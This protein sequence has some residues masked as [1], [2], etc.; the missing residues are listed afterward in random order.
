M[1]N[2]KELIEYIEDNLKCEDK[3]LKNAIEKL[4]K[5]YNKKSTRLDKIVKQSDRQQSSLKTAYEE[6]SDY[7]ENL[8]IKVQD[9]IKKRQDNE[10]MLMQQSKMA[11]MGEM[12]DAVA[13]QWKQPLNII[14][15]R[16]MMLGMDFEDGEVNKEYIQELNN[17]VS[18]QIKHMVNTLD[19]FRGFLRPNKQLKKFNI[20][21]TVNSVLLL[22][23]DEFIQNKISTKILE[24]KDFNI[25]GV[26]N[27]FKHIILNI[28]NNSKDAFVEK[29]KKKR[30]ITFKSYT[31]N[32]NL[33]LEI[34]D[35]AGGIPENI[36]DDIFKP[37]VTTKADD[38]GTGI[39]LYMSLQIA[40]KYNGD[41]IVENTDKGAKFSIKL[42]N[43]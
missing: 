14:S 41:I 32:S 37:N 35:N 23:K 5:N 20:L 38:K 34:E 4:I 18:S 19:E 36:I 17:Q 12:I 43:F 42:K 27:E 13:H 30:E 6:L 31:T 26:E 9:E 3:N 11:A 40:Q 2:E 10:R 25:L 7:K 33:I 28:I 21:K 15:V 16:V 8:E 24:S 22:T 39:G 29:N 1:E